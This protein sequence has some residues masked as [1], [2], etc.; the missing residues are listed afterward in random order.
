MSTGEAAGRPGARVPRTVRVLGSAAAAAEAA[1][2]LVV[3]ASREAVD[4]TGR[5]VLGLSG[6]ETP[7]PL[8]DRL[9]G[10]HADAVEWES[11]HV[12]WADERCVEP[13][14]P[15]SNYGRARTR[16][17]DRVPV[18]PSKIHR[19]RGEM[20]PPVAAGIYRA[21]LAA[22][23]HAERPVAAEA[24]FDVVL[25][26]VGADGHVASIFAGSPALDSVEWALDVHAPPETSPRWRVTLTPAAIG[27]ARHVFVLATGAGKAGAVASALTPGALSPAARISARSGVTWVLDAAA[28]PGLGRP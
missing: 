28:A 13:D 15:D 7:L 3:R 19:I 25:L 22:F 4:A 27:S 9:A 18:V 26:G 20:T 17:L 16:L 11:V 12:F 5:F 23:F 24:A 10:D 8:F 14:D 1:A 21:E 2:A 6:G